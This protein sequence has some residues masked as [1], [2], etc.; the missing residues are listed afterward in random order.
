MT[1]RPTRS[2]RLA[3]STLRALAALPIAL[4]ANAAPEKPGVFV[5]GIDGMDPVILERMLA[6]G[7]MPN[8]A[9]LRDE[10]AFQPLGTSTPPQSPVAW[11]SFVTGMNP[12]GHGIFDFIHRDPGH[13]QADLLGDAA[14][15]RS[16]RRAARVRLRDPDLRARGAQQP[17]R[18]AV[19]GRAP[20]ARRTRRGVSHPGQLPDAAVE[21][22]RARRDGNRGPARRLRHLHAVHRPAARREGEGRRPARARAGPRSRRRARHGERDPARS[23]R[24]VPPRARSG[25]RRRRLSREGRDDPPRRRPQGRGDRDRLGARAARAGRV[26]G[27]DRRRLR[28]AADGARLGVGRGALLRQGARA[29]LLGVRVTGEHLAREPRGGADQP[30]RVHRRSVHEPRLLLHQG[31]ARGDRSAQGR[32]V[33]RRRLPRAGGARAAGHPA[34]GRARARPLRARQRHVRLSLRHRPAVPHALAARRSEAAR[35]VR[36]IP[37]ATRRSR[38]AMPTTSSGSIATWTPSWARSASG[39]RPRRCCS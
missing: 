5:V 27:L 37:R 21:G 29:G 15:R 26:V 25:A 35:R 1:A 6:R 17:R 39:C 14:G 36:R 13:L 16:R 31:H 20:A 10:G 34:H 33:R 18:N 24:P 32:R 2:A 7:E 30:R 4:A 11:S 23:A 28:S 22:P 19:V 3:R 38:R 8:F 12:G 9:R